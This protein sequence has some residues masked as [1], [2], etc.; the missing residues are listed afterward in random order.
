MAKRQKARRTTRQE[1]R[2]SVLRPILWSALLG[3]VATGA[4]TVPAYADPPLPNTV[5]HTGTRPVPSGPVPLPGGSATAPPR[6]GPTAAPGLGPFAAQI[7][8]KE[9]EVATLG[10]RLLG[11]Q[12]EQ[13]RTATALQQAERHLHDTQ[14][15]LRQA[16]QK[17]GPTAVEA[18]KRAAERPPGAI[19]AD[20]HELGALLRIQK[21]QQRG[22]DSEG[23]ARDLLRAQAAEQQARTD[24]IA[25]SQTAQAA[26]V[27]YATAETTFKPREAELLNLKRR[28]VDKLAALDRERDAAEQR[29]GPITG[30]ETVAG[31]A[32]DPRALTAVRFARAQLGK[33]YQWA[34]E[35]PDR[36]DCSG[37]IWAAYRSRGADY[38]QLPR[39]S[40][41]QYNATRGRTVDRSALL[42]GDLIF[43]ASG[44]SW[45]SIHHMG[46]YVGDGKMIHAPST[47][48]VVK[49]STVW[50]SRFYAATRVIP[51]IPAPTTPPSSPPPTVRPTRP[52]PSPKPTPTP[53]RP[54]PTPTPTGP[55]PSP[56]STTPSPTPTPTPS[57]SKTSSPSTSPAPTASAPT[58]GPT[59]PAAPTHS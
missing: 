43:F 12:Q 5:P 3:T 49:I 6:P 27:A 50:W 47:G 14:V 8:A 36:Y 16:Q 31:N 13:V 22:G 4:M 42:P 18:F 19:G 48:D 38:D 26:R 33:P 53:T 10:E 56:S 24:H 45:T 29:L 11:L 51:A 52:A 35:G 2:L 37:L 1:P 25:A 54:R 40:R 55:K 30:G 28:N 59:T 20:L 32:A 58:A 17:L 21:G 39:V 57:P 7:L 44:S 34:A 23:P 41:D 15:A 9:T 46:M